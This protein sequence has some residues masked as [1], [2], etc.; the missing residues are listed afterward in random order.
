MKVPPDCV[1]V[2]LIEIVPELPAESEAEMR[3]AVV[4]VPV[5]ASVPAV[6]WRAPRM[7]LPEPESVSVPVPLLRRPP[8]FVVSSEA[9]VMFWLLVLMRTETV[10]FLMREERSVVMSAANCKKPCPPE[11]RICPIGK[12]RSLTFPLEIVVFPV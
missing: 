7:V 2:P 3:E 5:K 10:L 12:Y 6:A 11:K 9:K 8:E 4:N 1:S